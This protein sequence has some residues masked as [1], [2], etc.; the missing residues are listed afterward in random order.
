MSKR[1][2]VILG[3]AGTVGA[4]LARIL[5]VA[6]QRVVII[7]RQAARKN[8]TDNHALTRYVADALNLPPQ[9]EPLL[10]SAA[11]LVLAL[12]QA[13]AL[14]ALEQCAPHITPT[15]WVVNTCSGRPRSIP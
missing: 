6:G 4:F 1:P 10:Q 3:G 5:C 12:P 7:D 8:V 15:A 13:T 2:F 11:A 14:G 9:Y